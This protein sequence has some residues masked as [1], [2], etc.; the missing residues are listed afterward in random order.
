[1]IHDQ[2]WDFVRARAYTPQV[3]VEASFATM[4][5]TFYTNAKALEDPVFVRPSSGDVLLEYTYSSFINNADTHWLQGK[6]QVSMDYNMNTTVRAEGSKIII[7]QYVLLVGTYKTPRQT[8][9]VNHLDRHILDEFTL[10]I[11]D[12]GI[13]SVYNKLDIV[14]GTEDELE[15]SGWIDFAWNLDSVSD[16]MDDFIGETVERDFSEVR[17]E[18][19]ASNLKSFV[20]PAARTFSYRDVWFSDNGDMMTRFNYR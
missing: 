7:D 10:D 20:L 19:L 1:M 18:R 4:T 12:A 11:S 8:Y 15:T 5:Y 6:S 16:A 2:I 14:V 17:P 9:Y 13:T 3:T